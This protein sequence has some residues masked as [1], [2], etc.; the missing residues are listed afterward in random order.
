VLPRGVIDL[1]ADQPPKDLRLVAAN[2]QLVAHADLHPALVQLLL[3]A[4]QQAHGEAGW[5]HRVGEFPNEA[6]P[7]TDE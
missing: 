7:Q 4:A 2:A 3:Q 1:A 6:S 5:F